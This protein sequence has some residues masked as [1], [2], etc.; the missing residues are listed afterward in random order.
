MAFFLVLRA[1]GRFLLP[2]AY[3]SFHR[4]AY[5]WAGSLNSL[6]PPIEGFVLPTKTHNYQLSLDFLDLE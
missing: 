1:M 2:T 6:P 3:L 4:T 5:P